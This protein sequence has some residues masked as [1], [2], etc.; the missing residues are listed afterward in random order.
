[1]L[2]IMSRFAFLCLHCCLMALA[3]VEP[4][5]AWLRKVYP[6]WES[7]NALFEQGPANVQDAFSV[8]DGHQHLSPPLF[9]TPYIEA[10]KLAEGRKLSEV[11]NLPGGAPFISSFSG[12]LTVNKQYNSNLFFWFFP[13]LVCWTTA[14]MVTFA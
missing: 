6:S 11:K 5:S 14:I 13:P 9:L 4:S 8:A 7:A 3:L 1:F 2:A 10:G 12:F